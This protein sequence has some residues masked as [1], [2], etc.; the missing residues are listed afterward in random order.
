MI[1]KYDVTAAGH[2]CL[3]IIPEIPDTGETEITKLFT[4]G[5]LIQVN[6]AKICTGGT[7]SNTGIALKKMG[8]N[9][10]FMARVGD[11]EFG[12]LVINI[13]GKQGQTAGLSVSKQDRTSYSIVLA[14][15]GVDRIFLHDP[16]ANDNFSSADLNKEIIAQSKIF[17]FGYPPLMEACY[18]NQGEELEKIFRLAKSAGATT[19]LDMALP[20]PNSKAGK[21]N[22][23]KILEKILPFVDIFLPSIEEIFFMLEPEK[24]FKVKTVAGT[25]DLVDFI[26]P[27]EYYSIAETCLQLGSKIVALKAS[28]RGLYILTKNLETRDDLGVALPADLKNWSNREL[29]CPSFQIDKIASATGSGDSSIAGFLTAYLKGE[30][31]EKSLKFATCAGFQNLHELDAVSGIR[32]WDETVEMVNEK[33]MELIAIPLEN[34]DWGWDNELKL[35]V[36]SRDSRNR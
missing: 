16:G 26:K 2:I 21:A 27:E 32:S 22:W 17:H 14:P 18:Q 3:D 31:I 28:Y 10:A 19:S 30:S 5:K 1:K 4:P 35:W 23:K 29:W 20:D 13:L 11:D 24:Y 6:A 12:K 33:N 34:S 8:L 36:G 15:P 25:N 7:V 9:V